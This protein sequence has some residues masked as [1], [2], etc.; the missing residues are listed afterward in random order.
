M[1]DVL[2]VCLVGACAVV[3]TWLLFVRFQQTAEKLDG[4]NGQILAVREDQQSIDN[5]T[6]RQVK[7]LARAEGELALRGQLPVN[8][9]VEAYFETLATV[10]RRHGLT[11]VRQSPVGSRRY[12]GL[13]EQRFQYEVAGPGAGVL[14]FIKAIEESEFWA[15]VAY[16]RI[17]SGN[18]TATGGGTSRV[19]LLTISLFSALPPEMSGVA[20][21]GT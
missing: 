2:G 4:L 15:D 16:L 12:P 8:A 5:A 19:A 21:E 6:V 14:A 1:I 3:S 11:V 13:L 18:P 9:P 20:T 17:Q 7:D 10:A